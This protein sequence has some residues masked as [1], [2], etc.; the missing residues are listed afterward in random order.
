MTDPETLIGDLQHVPRI[1]PWTARAAV[2]DWANRF[3][4]YPYA[5]LAV[6]TWATRTAPSYD[7]PADEPAFGRAWRVLAGDHLNEITLLTLAWGGH[8]AD[9]R[10]L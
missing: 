3:D 9:A 8:H 2:A 7:W 1:G 4:L 6:R 5:D 10:L